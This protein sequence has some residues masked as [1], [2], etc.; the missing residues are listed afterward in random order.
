MNF[1]INY[2]FEDIEKE[3]IFFKLTEG[4]EEAME[5]FNS[6]S[7]LIDEIEKSGKQEIH[8]TD[9]EENVKIMGNVYIGEG[10]KIESGCI[11][12]GPVYIGKDCQLM[13]KEEVLAFQRLAKQ[14]VQDEH[15][16]KLTHDCFDIPKQRVKK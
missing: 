5:I 14:E 11:I 6:S 12:Q 16:Y 7:K 3:E 15:Y 8:T 9:I 10:T 1:K 13:Y 4:K 2:Y